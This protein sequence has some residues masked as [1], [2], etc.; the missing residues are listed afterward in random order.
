MRLYGK[1]FLRHAWFY[2]NCIACSINIRSARFPGVL[3]RSIISLHFFVLFLLLVSLIWSPLIVLELFCY[4][5]SRL[6]C[7]EM[8]H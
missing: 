5:V 6:R 3:I 8:L 2:D 1:T 7:E 4:F